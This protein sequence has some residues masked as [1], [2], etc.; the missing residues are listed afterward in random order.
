MIRLL[1]IIIIFLFQL[2]VFGQEVVVEQKILPGPNPVFTYEITNKHLRIKKT[3]EILFYS[4]DFKRQVYSKRLNRI[5]QDSLKLILSNMNLTSGK[6][7]YSGGYLDGITWTF[8]ISQ[9]S[10]NTYIILDN[11]YLSKYGNLLDFINRQLPNKRRYISFDF[12][13]IKNEFEIEN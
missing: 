12:F 1:F 2:S 11:Y 5:Q 6:D 9:D 4:V 10:I 7:Y 3:K 8:S 13:D